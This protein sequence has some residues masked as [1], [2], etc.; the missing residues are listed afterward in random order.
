[1]F[2]PNENPLTAEAPAA[3]C[4]AEAA[5]PGPDCSIGAARRTS[6]S[7]V[8]SGLV[9]LGCAGGLGVHGGCG[10]RLQ[11]GCT[12]HRARR[13]RVPAY[14]DLRTGYQ[15]ARG[16]RSAGDCLPARAFVHVCSGALPHPRALRESDPLE[17]AG[18]FRAGVLRSGD[19][20][21]GGYRWLVALS[22][23]SQVAADGQ[24][25]Q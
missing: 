11:S 21:G 7:A 17:L 8:F 5:R 9:G 18:N 20:S 1:M 25:F 16:D 6:S 19:H 2:D 13:P 23:D 4:C 14:T 15:R 3:E 10:V 24:V 22:A 12:V